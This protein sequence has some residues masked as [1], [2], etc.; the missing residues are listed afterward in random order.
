MSQ[1]AMLKEN[2]QAWKDA[3]G[4]NL[5]TKKQDPTS[6]RV[7]PHPGGGGAGVGRGAIVASG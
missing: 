5:P 7:R 4:A 1:I 6:R 3:C 2:P